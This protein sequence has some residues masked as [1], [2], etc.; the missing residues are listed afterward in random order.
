MY[1]PIISDSY[2]ANKGQTVNIRIIFLPEP[3]E[4][5]TMGDIV[6]NPGKKFKNNSKSTH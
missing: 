4:K 1:G 2:E 5:S 3:G 6:N